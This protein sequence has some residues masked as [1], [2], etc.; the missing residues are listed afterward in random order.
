[1]QFRAYIAL[2]SIASC[3]FGCS[4]GN[5]RPQNLP[6]LFPVNIRVLQQ[7]EPVSDAFVRLIPVDSAMPWSCGATTTADGHAKIMT[8]GRFEGAPQGEYKV[9]IS[10]LEMTP[11]IQAD[12]SDL[13]SQKVSTS[14][15]GFDLIEP[16]YSDIKSTPLTANV[17][18]N[19]LS[20]EFDVEQAVRLKR[21]GPP[22]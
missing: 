5:D 22:R 15:A 14:T 17:T 10:K 20:C 3:V 4:R 11:T 2:L 21:K 12:L 19:G 7:G 13:K 6:D 16:K 8:V 1:M 18:S 9:L